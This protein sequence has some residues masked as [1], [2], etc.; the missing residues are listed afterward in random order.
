MMRFLILSGYCILF[1][2]CS[3]KLYGQQE[4]ILLHLDK[5]NQDSLNKIILKKE[6]GKDY[7][8]LGIIYGGLYNYYLY[9]SFKDSAIFYADKAEDNAYK[10]GDSARYY[11]IQLQLGE[12]YSNALDF[13]TAKACYEKALQYYVRTKNYTLQGNAFGGLSYM[14]ELKKDTVNLIKYLDRMEAVNKLSRDTFNIVSVNHTR[15][16]IMMA[17]NRL[18]SAVNLLT[19]NVWLINHANTFGNGEHIRS[20]WLKLELG[21]LAE[22][23]YLKKNYGLAIRYLKEARQFEKQLSD[24]NDQNIFQNRILINSY[25]NINEK[26][27]AIKYLTTFFE[28]TKNAITNLSPERLNEITA[29]YEAEKKQRQIG[30][31][32][33]KDFLHQLT[34]SNQRKLNIAFAGIFFLIVIT[35]FFILKNIR[36]KRKIALELASKE[37]MYTEQLYKQKELETRNRITRDLHDD[38]GATLSSIKAYS[39]ILKDNPDKPLIAEL[40]QD[41]ASEMIE[42]LEVIAWATNPQHDNF[43]SLVDALLKFARPVT[44]AH[45]IELHFEKKG[46][47]DDLMIP[48]DVRQNVLLIFKEAINNM[49]KYAETSQ[50]HV[51]LLIKNQQLLLEVKDNGKGNDGSIKGGGAGIKNMH[52]RA[53]EM[54]GSIEIETAANQGTAVRLTIPHPFK[55]PSTWY[56][57][58][59]TS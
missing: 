58:K 28:K 26:D 36:Q 48:G 27:S 51:K 3:Y 49:I 16:Q 21:I 56:Q 5:L 8:A 22:C 45:N 23:Y 57:I 35:T 24:F 30:E 47:E 55:I 34:I 11:F 20:F 59:T 4:L 32:Q 44:H 19:K 25:I 43:K 13:K 37:M 40:I 12:L 31:L 50:C 7:K 54:N 42:R 39:E 14:Y 15:I 10:A 38:V 9:S 29:K 41:N 52:K 33:R 6:K 53:E 18:D 17:K 2:L 46:F 1:I